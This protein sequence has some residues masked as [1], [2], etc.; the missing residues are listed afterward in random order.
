M[1]ESTITFGQV[2]RDDE[3]EPTEHEQGTR[4]VSDR[5]GYENE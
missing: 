5:D 2:K 3:D 1:R 4:F